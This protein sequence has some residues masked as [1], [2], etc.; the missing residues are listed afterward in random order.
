NLAGKSA[1]AAKS[2][3]V[4]IESA[5]NA[6]A[7]GTKIADETANSLLEVVEKVNSVSAKIDEI[8][9]ASEEQAT[10]VTQL[11][12]GIEQISAVVQTNS[13]TSEESASASQELSGQA[14]MLKQVIGNFK[15]KNVEN[16]IQDE[17]Q[18][19][20]DLS[21]TLEVDFDATYDDKY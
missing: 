12:G 21:S 4:L 8:A 5:I 13:A 14:Q 17:F 6:I 3:T 15:L 16:I 2:T 20:I 1:E 9:T 18:K 11:K 19:N 10:A 7:N